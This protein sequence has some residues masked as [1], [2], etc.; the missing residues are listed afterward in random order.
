MHVS[1]PPFLPLILLLPVCPSYVC[2]QPF[3][4]DLSSGGS[5]V[6]D[7]YIQQP[8]HKET[9]L[10]GCVV[11]RPEK[12]LLW[13]QRRAREALQAISL[14]LAADA[15]AA[16][17]ADHAPD[18]GNYDFEL[19]IAAG[20]TQAAQFVK[21]EALLALGQQQEAADAWQACAAGEQ[22]S[23]AVAALCFWRWSWKAAGQ[24]D[25]TAA[26]ST[27][28]KL[29][30]DPEARSPELLWLA[31][32][33]VYHAGDYEHAKQLALQA[34]DL[35]CFSGEC[36]PEGRIRSEGARYDWTFD[37]LFYALLKLGDKDGAQ[38]AAAQRE[39]AKAARLAAAQ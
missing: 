12:T 26:I 35:G 22:Q 7:M 17:E 4:V 3:L 24:Q 28:T 34:I 36:V 14:Q 38:Q 32:F 9:T 23:S 19:A 20:R 18:D 13:K 31:A 10:T 6:H 2:L 37:V 1:F 29:L 33:K 27:V 15:A 8:G 39:L 30:E 5:F 21:A 25:L 16:Q 11:S